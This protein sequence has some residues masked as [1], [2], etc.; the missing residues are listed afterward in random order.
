MI[1]G[2]GVDIVVISRLEPLRH[3]QAFLDKVFTPCEQA[4]YAK[5]TTQS[6]AAAWAA[7]EAVS[8]ALGVPLG[9]I[10]LKEIE[11]LHK[12]SG[13]PYVRLGGIYAAQT[14]YIHISI[15]HEKQHAVA[16]AVWEGEGH[17]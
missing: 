5:R 3:K 10:G 8:K 1:R 9:E 4:H 16:M 15:T 11:I 7:K 12:P 13:Q 14:P 6:I 17:D 2:I